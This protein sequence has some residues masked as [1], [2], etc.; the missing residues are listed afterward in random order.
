MIRVFLADDHELVRDGVRRLLEDAG[1]FTVV[2]ET[3]V[4]ES[5]LERAAQVGWDVLVLDLELE[6]LSGFEV[7]R[8]V[9]EIQPGLRVLVMSMHPER[10]VAARLVRAGAAGYLSKGR[11]AS[12]LV[13]ALRAIHAG[14]QFVSTEV[15]AEL[16]GQTPSDATLSDR[17][18][19][20]LTLLASG[21]SP[22]EI[23]YALDLRAST[24]STHLAHIKTKI[25]ARSLAELVQFALKSGLTRK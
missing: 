9:L 11:P 17:E 19:E 15:T 14:E 16:L 25:G 13:R 1:D 3:S 10:Q 20:V 7:L 8:R 6:G 23:G 22:S 5:V 24:V 4:G 2:G 18:L 12:D 21:K